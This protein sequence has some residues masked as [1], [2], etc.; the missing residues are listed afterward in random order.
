MKSRSELY[1]IMVNDIGDVLYF[2]NAG[3]N[4]IVSVKYNF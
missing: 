2:I 4:F 3:T 1:N